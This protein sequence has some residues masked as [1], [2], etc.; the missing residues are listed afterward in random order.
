MRT[1]A[2]ERRRGQLWCLAVVVVPVTSVLVAGPAFAE[3]DPAQVGRTLFCLE[4][5]QRQ[6]VA[7]AGVVLDLATASDRPGHVV[8]DGRELTVEQW[9]VHDPQAF[10]EAC[11]AV[12]AAAKVRS[13]GPAESTTGPLWILLLPLFVGAALGLLSSLFTSGWRERIAE[14]RRYAVVLRDAATD[15]STAVNSFLAAATDPDRRVPAGTA[16]DPPRQALLRALDG[17]P[18]PHSTVRLRHARALLVRGA[19]GESLGQG[20]V[21]DAQRDPRSARTRRIRD[22]LVAM[23]ADIEETIR[24]RERPVRSSLG[25]CLPR[26]RARRRPHPDRADRSADTQRRVV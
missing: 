16:L 14:A 13:G 15:F 1:V 22:A 18:R 21:S 3:E 9:R 26:R 17:L 23:R 12:V 7:D 10:A 19:L 4:L 25:R 11:A 6:R 24:D 20:W 5:G 2:A 8:D